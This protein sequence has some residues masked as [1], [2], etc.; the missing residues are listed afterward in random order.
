MTPA[1]IYHPIIFF[2]VTILASFLLGIVAYY[3]T[4]Q[5]QAPLFLFGLCIPAITALA[6]IFTSHNE[7]LIRDFWHRLFLFHISSSYLTIILFLMP[8]TMI[9]ATM[10]SL[11]FGYSSKQF[12]INDNMSVMKGWNAL[13][14][15]IP[16]ILAPIIEELGWRGYGVD[17]LMVHFNLFT[18]SVLF[19]LLW[20]V[21]H[22]PAF[23]I[24]GYYHNQLLHLGARYVINFFVS[25]FVITFLM[26]WIYYKTGRSIPAVMLFHAMINLSSMVFKTEPDTKCIATVIL[27]VIVIGIIANVRVFSVFY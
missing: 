9:L 27:S 19:G 11:L 23:F 15:V 16:L 3:G 17:S 26:N 25:V 22:L 5:L 1:V 13:G 12:L 8:C 2:T 21:W 24:K 10:I 6:L 18:T 7:L 4:K 14:I 20:A